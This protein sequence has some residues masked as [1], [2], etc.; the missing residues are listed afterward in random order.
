M[1]K[2]NNRKELEMQN[3]LP[4]K[5]FVYNSVDFGS[6][7][8]GS[9]GGASKPAPFQQ[10]SVCSHM[11]Y[12]FFLIIIYDICIYLQNKDKTKKRKGKKKKEKFG[13]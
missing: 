10:K 11:F 2:L 12:I 9:K 1:Q 7:Q 5:D 4:K 3:M 13:I 6:F 8:G